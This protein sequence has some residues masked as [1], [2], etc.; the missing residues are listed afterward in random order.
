MRLPAP[1]APAVVA[2]LAVAAILAAPHLA[3]AQERAPALSGPVAMETG[4]AARGWEA[5]GRLLLGERGLCTAAL[6]APRLI[7][8]AAHCLFDRETSARLPDG[9]ITFE[10]GWRLGR[11]EAYR[12]V[13][14]TIVDPDYVYSG[15]DAVERIGHDLAL[16]E[17][18]QA[19]SL[20][21]L[22]PFGTGAL[23]VPGE[24]VTVVSYA[25]GR[26]EA[27]AIERDCPVIGR[28]GPALILGCSVD[29]GASGAPVFALHGGG[30][31]LVSVIVAKA[32]YQGRRVALAVPLGERLEALAAAMTVGEGQAR[33]GV[34]GV[35]ILSGGGSGGAH[36]ISP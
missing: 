28:Q 10:A 12:G 19:I 24:G 32:E 29:F 22:A 20:P 35:R 2:V 5:V 3:L 16:L 15:G 25:Q 34:S 17:L 9:L 33:G 8:S 23:P 18:D 36:F 7:V 13:S 11:A 26:T 4:D 31:E 14:R 1:L 6:V 21:Q 27:P 30:A